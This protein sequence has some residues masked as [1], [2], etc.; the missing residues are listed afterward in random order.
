MLVSVEGSV[1]LG[2]AGLRIL[3]RWVVW[4]SSMGFNGSGYSDFRSWAWS[5]PVTLPVLMYNVRDETRVAH[6]RFRAEQSRA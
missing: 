5:L 1:G 3:R 6:Q 2:W 4:L